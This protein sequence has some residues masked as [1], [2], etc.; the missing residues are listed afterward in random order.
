MERRLAAVLFADV[1]GYSRLMQASE[2]A[3]LAALR[4]RHAEII[5]PV[6]ALHKGRVVKLIGDGVLV[7]FPSAVGAVECGVELQA[8]LATANVGITPDRQLV[9]RMGISLGD[10]IVQGDDLYG[11]GVNIASRLE[12]LAVPGSVVVSETVYSQVRGKVGFRFED[13]GEKTLKNIAQPV[14]AYMVFNP[15]SGQSRLGGS[16]EVHK[17]GISIAVLPFA[18]VSGDPEQEYFSDGITDDIITDLSKISALKVLS[19][20]TA[21]TFKGRAVNVGHVARELQV[22]YV[23]EG[24]VRK[25][26]GRVR[27]SAQL[28]DAASDAHV[29]AERYDRDLSDVFE[30]QDDLSLAI[31][32]ALKVRL[33]PEEECAIEARSTYDTEAYRMYLMGRR[34]L[35]LR[36]A[37][38]YEIALRFCRQALQS[39]PEYARAWA[40]SALCLSYLNHSGRTSDSGFEAAQKALSVDPTLAEAHAAMGRI[41][42]EE[43]K[44]EEALAAHR[45]SLRLEPESFDVHHNFGTTYLELGRYEEAVGHFEEAARLLESD[46]TSLNLLALSLKSLGRNEESATATYRALERIEREVAARPD[47]ANALAHGALALARLG[48]KERAS[49]WIDRALIIEPDDATDQYN[50]ACAFAQM[51]EPERAMDLLEASIPRKPTEFLQWMKL[52]LDLEPVRDHPRYLKLS[53]GCEARMAHASEG[54]DVA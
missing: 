15:P 53:A 21:F 8:A 43:G 45:E 12:H 23:L 35:N 36:G 46:H 38:N 31:V 52:D 10:V 16:K 28:I 3:T 25:S 11:E 33:L 7:E 49:E 29:W 2:A 48:E 51:G 24:S 14:R 34:Y 42:A 9:Y 1:A 18:N 13:M 32:S 22:A 47:N 44:F 27:I 17:A 41:M 54:Q 6:V 19:R 4:A 39:D 26:G 20:S 40:L 37:R 30:L 5:E 50:L